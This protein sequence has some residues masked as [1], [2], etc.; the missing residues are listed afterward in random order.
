MT[1]GVTQA[2]HRR[3]AESAPLCALLPVARVSTGASPSPSLPRAVLT[4]ES[5]QPVAAC[6][7]GSAVTAVGVRIEVFHAD[8]DAAAAIVRQAAA[9]L[10]RT[11]FPLP[12]GG[13]VVG[14]RRINDSE[15]QQED[16]TWR[17]AVE[18]L[19]TVHWCP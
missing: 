14:I 5:D 16:G 17:M 6:N 9:V 1:A 10:D 19:C 3:W 11:D 7:D 18:L 2:I 12:E 13:R 15:Q 8:Y 4:K